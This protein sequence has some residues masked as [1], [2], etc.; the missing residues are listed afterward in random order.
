MRARW[1]ARR[2]LR[3]HVVQFERAVG[4]RGGAGI[5]A[6]R[7]VDWAHPVAGSLRQSGLWRTQARPSVH[8]GLAIAVYAARRCAGGGAGIVPALG[9]Q[10]A[11]AV[12]TRTY[13]SRY[14]PRTNGAVA[15]APRSARSSRMSV[16]ASGS[17]AS[18]MMKHDGGG[19]MSV[20]SLVSVVR[21]SEAAV[22]P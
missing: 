15:P 11:N 13:S 2:R 16:N 19:W 12:F 9:S 3:Q 20:R 1:D 6:R 4:I 7:Q 22:S 10:G 8:D 17:V 18:T 14:V 21:I 5:R